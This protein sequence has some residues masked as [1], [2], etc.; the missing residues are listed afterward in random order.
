MYKSIKDL[1]GNK[2]YIYVQINA[3]AIPRELCGGFL[4]WFYGVLTLFWMIVCTICSFFF[5]LYC[6]LYSEINN[7][8]LVDIKSKKIHT[9]TIYLIIWFIRFFTYILWTIVHIV[10]KFENLTLWWNHFLIFFN[11][12]F[13]VYFWLDMIKSSASNPFEQCLI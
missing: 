11:F 12:F 13:C 9:D 2:R 6:F 7:I 1:T 3:E 8:L 10:Q 4:L 5:I